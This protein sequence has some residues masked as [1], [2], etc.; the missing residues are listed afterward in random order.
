[1]TDL[2]NQIKI[3]QKVGKK[4]IDNTSLKSIKINGINKVGTTV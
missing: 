1:M 4:A 3:N 2:K